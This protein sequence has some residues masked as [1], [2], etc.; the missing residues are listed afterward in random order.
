MELN[1]IVTDA[2]AA[3]LAVKEAETLGSALVDARLS[4]SQ[5]R[6]IFSE[7]RQIEAMLLLGSEQQDQQ[8]KRRLTLLKPKMRYRARKESGRGVDQLVS[9]LTPAIDEVNSATEV[10]DWKANFQR[11]VEFFEAILAYHKAAGGK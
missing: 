4:T 2:N 3:E 1:K 6:A 7:V 8:A 5:I 10:K 11:F 9:V